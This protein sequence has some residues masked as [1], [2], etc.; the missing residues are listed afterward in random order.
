VVTELIG[1]P[2]GGRAGDRL[3]GRLV[4]VGVDEWAKR[5]GVARRRLSSTWNAEE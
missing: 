1:Q 4:V 3:Q 2:L 5:K